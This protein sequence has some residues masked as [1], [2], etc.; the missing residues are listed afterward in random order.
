MTAD[1]SELTILISPPFFSVRISPWFYCSEYT[2]SHT[3][4]LKI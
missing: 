2:T 1:T 3:A 4:G